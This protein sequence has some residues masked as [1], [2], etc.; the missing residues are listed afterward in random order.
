VVSATI[1]RWQTMQLPLRPHDPRVATERRQDEHDLAWLR[2]RL[3]RDCS[4]KE[5]E[6]ALAELSLL[7]SDD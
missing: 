2:H 6:A 1:S 5:L 3:R 7:G 4:D